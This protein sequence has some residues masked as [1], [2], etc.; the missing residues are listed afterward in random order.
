MRVGKQDPPWRAIRGFQ[1]ESGESLVH[2]HNV[3]GGILGGDLLE[4]QV[5]LEAG[6]RAQ[7][8]SV[9]A[10]RIYRQKSDGVCAKQT[11]YF[12]VAEGALLEYLP[13]AVIPYADSGF[14]QEAKFHLAPGAGLIAWEILAAGRTAYGESFSFNEFTS[15]TTIHSPGRLLALERYS[16]RP[17]ERNMRS[18]GSI[19]A[20]RTL[21]N[22]VGLPD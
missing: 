15:A 3:S 5:N 2:L 13:D 22:H 8:T 11:S 21:R 20:F 6:A 9:G 1:N 19:R 16:L 17:K 12:H 4:L 18:S 10:T 7:V 14:H